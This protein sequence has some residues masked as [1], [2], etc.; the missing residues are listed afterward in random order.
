MAAARAPQ[1]AQLVGSST[2]DLVDVFAVRAG[3]ELVGGLRA[4]DGHAAADLVALCSLEGTRRV[5]QSENRKEARPGAIAAA[6]RRA[7]H[8]AA[9]ILGPLSARDSPAQWLRHAKL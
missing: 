8:G 3:D 5:L 2:R 1:A 4:K 7:G 6:R 9:V